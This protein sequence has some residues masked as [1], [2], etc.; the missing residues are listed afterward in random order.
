MKS[1][2]LPLATIFFMTYFYRDAGGRG[3]G[4]ELLIILI[5]KYLSLSKYLIPIVLFVI[6]R[7]RQLL[8]YS[9]QLSN[10]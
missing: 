8:R 6:I 3:A 1:M 9:L 2:W 4:G 10:I 5:F 7:P